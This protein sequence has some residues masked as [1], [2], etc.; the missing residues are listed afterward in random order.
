MN[1]DSV[2]RNIPVNNILPKAL[3]CNYL[4]LIKYWSSASAIT[5]LRSIT[6]FVA[7]NETVSEQLRKYLSHSKKKNVHTALGVELELHFVNFLSQ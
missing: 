4:D 2:E 5:E 6:N 7:Y 3:Q 1:F